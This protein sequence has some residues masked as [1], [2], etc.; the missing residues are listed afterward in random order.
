MG[1]TLM[2]SNHRYLK[3][4][5][6]LNSLILFL[7]AGIMLYM[8]DSIL[9]NGSHNNESLS[10]LKLNVI[11]VIVLGVISISCFKQKG[12]PLRFIKIIAL[13][14][15]TYHILSMF[16]WFGY[17][18]QEITD[19]I[20]FLLIHAIGAFCMIVLYFLGSDDL[21]QAK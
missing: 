14:F 16:H 19:N 2:M 21:Q 1:M 17:W 20:Y 18:Q 9:L 13:S 8:P 12:L 7:L 10:L 11:V 6:V 3:L 5:F 4:S 15:I